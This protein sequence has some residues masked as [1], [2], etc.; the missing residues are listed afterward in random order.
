[1]GAAAFTQKGDAIT[2]GGTNRLLF[3]TVAM[4]SSYATGGDTLDMPGDISLGEGSVL[5]GQAGGYVLEYDGTNAK[6][7]AYRDNGTATAAALPEV[8]AAV[9]LS[10]VSAEC[11]AIV[12]T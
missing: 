9:N 7:K 1:M 12:T 2:L 10:A 11:W 5:I 8:A 6:V 3:G 4:S